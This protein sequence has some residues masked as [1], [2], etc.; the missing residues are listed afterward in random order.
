MGVI[1]PGSGGEGGSDS[2]DPDAPAA[3]LSTTAAAASVE[4]IVSPLFCLRVEGCVLLP[5]E[6][7]VD[8]MGCKVVHWK[9]KHLLA[10]P[11]TPFGTQSDFYIINSV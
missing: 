2:S 6:A 3:G 10:G 5:C 8:Q 11:L 1:V 9:D 7:L 4:V